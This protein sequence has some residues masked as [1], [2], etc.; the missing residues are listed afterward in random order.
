VSLI[1]V[2]GGY[3][4]FGARLCRRLAAD[5]HSLIVAGRSAGRAAR[6]AATLPDATPLALDRSKDIGPVLES[7]GPDLVV[8]AAGPFQ[9]N[10]YRVPRACVAARIPYLDLA[11]ARDFVCGIGALD[12]EA[13]TAGVA[14]LSGASTSPALTGAIA[15]RL[16]DG[17]DRADSVEIALS[18][19]NRAAG[20]DAVLAAA[21]SYAGRPVRL[22]RGRRWTGAVGWQEMKRADFAFADGR[23]GLF[24]RFVALADLADLELLPALL[25]GRPTVTFR[26]GTELGFQMLALWL[27]S[28]PVRW[29]W[30]KSLAGASRAIV[31]LYRLTGRIGGKRSAM[32]VT[33]A[34][35]RGDAAVE[36]RWTVVAEQGE[37]LEI[38][39]LA[40][41]LLADD[42]LSGRIPPGAGSPETLLPLDR[43][44]ALFARLPVR[45]EIVERPLPP[46]LYARAMGEGWAALPPVVRRLHDLSRDG[47]AAGE[48]TV[49]RGR[50]LLARAIAAAMRFPKSGTWPLHVAFAEADGVER[51]TRDFGGHIFSSELSQSDGGVTERFGALRFDFDLP[52]GPHG[53]HMRLRR[54][55]LFRLPMPLVLAPCIAARECE[56]DGRFCFEVAVALPLIGPV[57]AYSGWLE[58]L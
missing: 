18:A 2:I 1:L 47:G 38:P 36:R 16:A 52:S 34:G 32:R 12:A 19:A 29:R 4:G 8:D 42:I 39:T 48:G 21:L 22:W 14:V 26:A 49:S 7:E 44:E 23:G 54:W 30:V 20:G 13:R 58:P 57:V 50:G 41:E 24:G 55:S 40:A 3:G 25:P 37:G 15:R 27:L 46:P 51:W 31:A 17:L 45:T 53:L 6:F 56:Q 5:G 33:L 28:W 43:F 9:G 35:R 10:D 11:D